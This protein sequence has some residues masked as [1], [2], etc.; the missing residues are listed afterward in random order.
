[1]A[2]FAKILQA[3]PTQLLARR[4]RLASQ[5]E[6][7]VR[8]DTPPNEKR[9][10]LL[11]L[12]EVLLGI[13]ATEKKINDDAVA[14]ALK[15]ARMGLELRKLVINYDKLSLDDLLEGISFAFSSVG[16]I[17]GRDLSNLQ[18]KTDGIVAE[19]TATPELKALVDAALERA[20]QEATAVISGD[21]EQAPA[22]G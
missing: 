5:I 8:K 13:I 12:R 1:M 21:A 15:A 7:A 3:N 20:G 6:T 2:A 18:S 9:A 16:T 4:A 14:Q 19:L 11:Q 10:E 22:C 17:T